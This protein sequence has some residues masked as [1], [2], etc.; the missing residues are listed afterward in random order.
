MRF[1][2]K[3]NDNVSAL[4][5]LLPYLTLFG[6]FLVYPI[7]N[8]FW[9]SLHDW[10]VVG[11]NRPFIGLQNY[12][13]MVADPVF[14]SSLGNTVYFT[15]LS[16]PLLVIT[17]LFFAVLLNQPLKGRSLFRGAIFL[18]YL[19]SISVVGMLWLWML[20]PRYGLVSYYWEKLFSVHLNLLGNPYTA[21]PAIVLTTVWWTVGYNTVIYLAGLQDI[22]DELREAA[23]IDGASSWQVFRYVTLPLLRRVTLYI[24][25]V[26]VI[27]SFQIFGQVY[28]MTKGGPFGS[29]RVLVQY[30]YENGFRYWRMGYASAMAY[31]LLIVILIFTIIQFRLTRT[32]DV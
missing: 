2:R 13:N 24:T 18:P 23:R 3:F 14:W 16:T 27:K 1:S 26:Q 31:A 19:L 25:V 20:Q 17:G 11:F 5:F 6:A 12:L 22:P 28:I 32:E 7:I 21:M 29:T 9:V 15:A 8:G 10:K 4:V 30:I